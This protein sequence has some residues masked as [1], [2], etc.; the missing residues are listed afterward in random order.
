MLF[1]RTGVSSL[2]KILHLVSFDRWTGA[3][4]PALAEV[5]ALRL[6]GADARF[7][8]VGGR[9]LE[10]RLN[11]IPWATPMVSRRQNPWT[12]LSDALAVRRYATREKID[13]LHAHQPWDHT[14]ARLA[15]GR[16]FVTVRTIHSRRALRDPF[17]RWLLRSDGAVA[18][19][20]D[21]ILLDRGLRGREPFVTPPPLDATVFSPAGSN[22]RSLYGIDP[23]TPVVG[24]IGKVARGRGFEDAFSVFRRIRE[25]IS[26]AKLLVIG[27]GPH[28]PDL[29]SLS[30]TQEIDDAVI[31]TGYRDADL[32][33][34]F[35]AMDV[36][37]FTA[38]GS[39]AG[40][41]AV[42]EAMG[43]GTP[44]VC[45]PIEGVHSVAGELANRLVAHSFD[46]PDLCG[47]AL[48]VLR[49]REVSLRLRC[50]E[51]ASSR[52]FHI[53]AERLLEM[54]GQALR[55]AR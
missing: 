29:E 42:S 5:E 32:A 12:L 52:E 50:V 18:V 40:H 36:M 46:P 2:L 1:R 41:R 31:W 7:A 16:R 49:D 22:A 37:L 38:E 15:A 19:V 54:Y 24:V 43:C 28:R 53:C 6:S 33:E 13:L 51:V 34:H 3:V 39:D 11:G 21:S 23:S 44:V 55:T 10:T 8:F 25:K 35:R 17:S 20:N 26:D 47:I 45:F 9:N 48:E 14:I 4:A 30:R 27:H